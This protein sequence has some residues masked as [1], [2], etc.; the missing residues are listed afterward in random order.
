M[1]LL[2]RAA[3]QVAR[4][5]QSQSS[6]AT[7]NGLAANLQQ[8]RTMGGAAHHGDPSQYVTYAGLSLSKPS[9]W[10]Y[11]LSKVIGSVMWFW[12]FK[13]AYDEWDHKTKGLPAIFEAEGL[14]DD[15]GHGHG[16]H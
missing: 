6:I 1:S 14:D 7:T 16:H 10:E 9:R 3:A 12:V 8:A 4:A 11:A 5:C 15:H 13:M 2:S